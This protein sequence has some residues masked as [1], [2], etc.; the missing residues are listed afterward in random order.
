MSCGCPASY[1][2]SLTEPHS[3]AFPSLCSTC[4]T[5]C[6]AAPYWSSSF[7]HWDFVQT[8]KA[9]SAQNGAQ[10]DEGWGD[11]PARH[12][13]GPMHDGELRPPGCEGVAGRRDERD[14]DANV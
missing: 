4:S 1:S 12:S 9:G 6:S 14:L 10:D 2:G 11:R 3:E 7:R 8:R 5:S 13:R